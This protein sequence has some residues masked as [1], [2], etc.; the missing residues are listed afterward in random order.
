MDGV[1]MIRRKDRDGIPLK[2]YHCRTRAIDAC[3]GLLWYRTLE[4]TSSIA[5]T[6]QELENCPA[7]R[8]PSFVLLLRSFA[9]LTVC[10]VALVC[11]VASLQWSCEVKS[12]STYGGFFDRGRMIS[13][14]VVVA[15]HFECSLLSRGISNGERGERWIASQ[16]SLHS[17]I[18]A[19]VRTGD[20][21]LTH[22]QSLVHLTTTSVRVGNK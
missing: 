17:P 19:L 22:R 12:W 8:K 2:D 5:A 9:V 14:I 13:S 21:A 15:S 6:R 18:P 10:V 11:L 20:T 1:W 4:C 3:E 7:V 16:K